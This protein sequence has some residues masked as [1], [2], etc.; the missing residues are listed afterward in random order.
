MRGLRTASQMVT[1][2]SSRRSEY[3]NVHTTA[4]VVGA[5]ML[6]LAVSCRDKG[7]GFLLL[8]VN[9]DRKRG[10]NGMNASLKLAYHT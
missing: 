8:P 6:Q 9:C 1:Q 7:A 3:T 5:V 10:M 4:D 2:I